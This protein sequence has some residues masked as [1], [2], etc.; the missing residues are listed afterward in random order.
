MLDGAKVKINI[1]DS[2][3]TVLPM[4]KY[5]VQI[6]DVNLKTQFN[7]F[8]QIEEDVLNYEFTVLDNKTMD[9]TNDEGKAEAESIR[10]RK[11]WKRTSLSLNSKSWLY[12]LASAVLGEMTKDQ[13][14]AF[15]P[16]DIIDKQ[17][18]V[19]VEIQEGTGKNAGNQYNNIISFAKP[20]KE[21]TPFDNDKSAKGETRVSEP[22]V[23]KMDD[24]ESDDFIKGLEDDKEET[25]EKK[26]K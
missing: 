21:L 22:V 8:K 25:E 20:G 3:F 24:E 11:L 5:T 26:S 18:D 17:V 23:D 4:D 7:S 9:V 10:G 12:K 19:M 14:E 1:S 15:Q 2:T 13:K 6:T 16:E